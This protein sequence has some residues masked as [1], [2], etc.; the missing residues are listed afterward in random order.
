MN[1][2]FGI[3]QNNNSVKA[4]CEQTLTLVKL[5]IDRLNERIG[6]RLDLDS[7]SEE[8]EDL[9]FFGSKGIGNIP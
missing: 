7:K 6:E 5:T 9:K 4:F 1:I 3:T 2:Y 8:L